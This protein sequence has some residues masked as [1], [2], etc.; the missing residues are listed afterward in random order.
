VDFCHLAALPARPTALLAVAFAVA[1]RRFLQSRSQLFFCCFSRPPYF[2]SRRR[3]HRLRVRGHGRQGLQGLQ[4]R[5]GGRGS[6]EDGPRRLAVADPRERGG[7]G[8]DHQHHG[9]LAIAGGEVSAPPLAPTIGIH[10]STLMRAVMSPVLRR[11]RKHA[12]FLRP[13]CGIIEEPSE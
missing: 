3:Q 7:A 2:F 8:A 10:E 11:P 6:R 4:G 5:E 1:R 13:V 9:E 12:C